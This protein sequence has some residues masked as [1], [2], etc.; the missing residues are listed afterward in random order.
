MYRGDFWAVI[1]I[2]SL[3][4]W[5]W[6]DYSSGKPYVCWEASEDEPRGD[7]MSLAEAD[8][9]LAVETDLPWATRARLLLEAE[10]WAVME[11]LGCRW[12]PAPVREVYNITAVD[13]R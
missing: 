2:G 8:R 4:L 9:W 3:V 7:P 11:E 1:K 13:G 5:R 12:S 10:T 6:G